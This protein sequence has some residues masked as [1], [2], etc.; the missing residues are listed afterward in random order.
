MVNVIDDNQG[1]EIRDDI[2]KEDVD[3]VVHYLVEWSPTLM[4]KYVLSKAKGL[5]NKFE[6]RLRAQ[7]MRQGEKKEGGCL[8]PLKVGKKAL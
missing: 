3:G 2:A 7:G 5:V 1:S 6:A 8:H 4:P